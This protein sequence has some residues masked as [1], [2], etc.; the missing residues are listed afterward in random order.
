MKSLHT[1]ALTSPKA[2]HYDATARSIRERI[3]HA[4]LFEFAALLI[5]APLFAL[6]TGRPI[7]DVGLMTLIIGTIAIIWNFI[8]NAIFDRMTRSFI[9]ERSLRVRIIHAVLFELGLIVMTIPLIAEILAMTWKD[10]FV[11][12]IG[13]ILFFLP[14]TVIFNWIYDFF[15]K[16]LWIRRQNL[17]R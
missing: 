16:V 3:S 6:L 8:Y 7:T 17:A 14:Y 11:L 15:R 9:K 10:A 13:I 12:D 5:S 1:H 4:L 2:T